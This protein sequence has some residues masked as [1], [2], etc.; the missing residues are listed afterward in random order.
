M[1][2]EVDPSQ[3][4]RWNL[5]DE[6]DTLVE[7]ILELS[8]PDLKE[9]PMLFSTKEEYGGYQCENV[10]SIWL[11][12]RDK[13]PEQMYPHIKKPRDVGEI[14]FASTMDMEVDP[15]QEN[16]WNLQ[17]EVDTLVED[18]LELS[19]SDLKEQPMLFST[20]EEYGDYQCEN[21]LSIWLQLRD[22]PP[23]QMYPHIKKPRD[24]GEEIKKHLEERDDMI[25]EASVHDIG[26]VTFKLSG[27]WIAESIHKMVRQGI[28]IWAPKLYLGKV[29]INSPSLDNDTA[30]G[31]RSAW[32]RHSYII[33]T[34]IRM[35]KY[36]KADITVF[37]D[38]P[39]KDDKEKAQ[40]KVKK[41]F[42]IEGDGIVT[43]S[44]VGPKGERK[45]IIRGKKDGG[46]GNASK[47][48]SKLWY[49]L[50]CEKANWIVNVI[51]VQQQEYYE[52]CF[53]AA[54][55]SRWLPEDRYESPGASYAGYR[56]CSNEVDK[57][58][59]FLQQMQTESVELPT[60]LLDNALAYT[61]LKAHR[62]ADCT[63]NLVEMVKEEGNTIQHLCKTQ[64]Q[65][66]S[67]TTKSSEDV[68]ELKKASE[69]TL[70]EGEV[71]EEGVERVL[72]L[73]LLM[74][75]EVL[76]E[77]CVSILPHILCKYL[78]DLSEKFERYR[79]FY[80]SSV[81]E[82]GFVVEPTTKLLLYEA[83][84]VVMEKCFH[85]LGINSESS[86]PEGLIAQSLLALSSAKRPMDVK[87]HVADAESDNKKQKRAVG[88]AP[89]DSSITRLLIPVAR[90]PPKNPRFEPFSISLN[91]RAD[92]DFKRGK[93]LGQISVS[94]NIG[95][96]SDA[97]VET[98]EP[99]CG[100][101]HLFN[102]D[103]CDSEDMVNFGCLYFGN[104]SSGQSIP[105]SSYLE[106]CMKLYVTNEKDAVF[107]LCDHESDI[108][109]S[110]FW[111][112]D[113]D[114]TCCAIKV[115]GE[116]GHVMM[117]YILLKDAVDAAIELTCTLL[118]DNLKV[119]GRILAYYGNNFD[120]QCEDIH[121]CFQRSFYTALLY[122]DDPSSVSS[123]AK[124]P[125]RK[126]L[127]AVP[128][129][130][131]CLVIQFKLTDESGIEI[132]S[133]SYEFSSQTKGSIEKNI[134]GSGCS[135][136]LKVDWSQGE[137]CDKAGLYLLEENQSEE[138]EMP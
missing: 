39:E 120:Y 97:W 138:M 76:K 44:V 73:H 37:T 119:Y 63:L 27:K 88:G 105:F 122:R 98:F 48:L 33:N 66:R 13:P 52:M 75:T 131:G 102:R 67:F 18:I 16:R 90:D 54:R 25:K 91:I 84:A 130:D 136:C 57:L 93:L 101:V 31:T 104:I 15:S 79:K 43:I 127:M 114:S 123:G 112:E 58:I 126:S 121:L 38:Y 78:H 22:K 11:E 12:L 100:L 26:F 19:F 53:T 8:F 74:F 32:F 17:D 40:C 64:A 108:R 135:F 129:K 47:D 30:E 51:P 89:E 65:I 69:L 34:L 49:G 55:E 132:L 86:S 72:G 111:K 61:F 82:V 134:K 137:G 46:F 56:T 99:E 81:C 2:M 125:L 110:E 85:L 23:E 80:K 107:Q 6:V 87:L 117:H 133:K 21:V 113:I 116:D 35:L 24:V 83:T 68:D 70:G 77:S 14:Y 96:L 10:L 94:D 42:S 3:E 59:T 41:C 20:K 92:P 109:F 45:P 106:I 71:W 115:A 7:D 50:E 124:I 118:D 1:D 60:T 62:L 4:N 5:Q 9:Q 128:N 95:L 29:M 28:E 103:W 36:S